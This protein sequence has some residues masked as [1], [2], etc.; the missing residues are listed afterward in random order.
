[1]LVAKC[2][3]EIRMS[4]V[5]RRHLGAVVDVNLDSRRVQVLHCEGSAEGSAKGGWSGGGRRHDG[6]G[7]GWS[8][9]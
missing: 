5:G 8:R 6:I 1:M 7:T 2:E 9:R 4:E 3:P